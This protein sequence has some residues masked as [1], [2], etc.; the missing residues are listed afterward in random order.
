M[1][2]SPGRFDASYKLEGALDILQYFI[3][4]AVTLLCEM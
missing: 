1:A 2:K 3:K 4:H